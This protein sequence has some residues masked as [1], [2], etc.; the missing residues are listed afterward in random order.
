M[1]LVGVKCGFNPAA[2]MNIFCY[3]QMVDQ[4]PV[5]YDSNKEDPIIV[6]LPHKQ[7]KFTW[8][9]GKCL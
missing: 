5:T 9:N 3:A 4:Y 8:E 1:F 6:N 2:M 7:V